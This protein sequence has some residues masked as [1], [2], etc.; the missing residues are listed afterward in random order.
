[1]RAIE[2]Y[3][4]LATFFACYELGLVHGMG[5]RQA[6]IKAIAFGLAWPLMVLHGIYLTH[7]KKPR[8]G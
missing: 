2:Y 4:L 6:F 5:G 3:F 7:F 1:M 8:R